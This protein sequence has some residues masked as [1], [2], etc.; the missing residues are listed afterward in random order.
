MHRYWSYIWDLIEGQIHT[1][2]AVAGEI[3]ESERE[4]E[5][6]Q[7]TGFEAWPS[8]PTEPSLWPH[9]GQQCSGEPH[10]PQRFA[11]CFTASPQPILSK[12]KGT[13]SFASAWF[14]IP[15]ASGAS[16]VPFS[17]Q[18]WLAGYI[19][20]KTIDRLFSKP[21]KPSFF[22]AQKTA[23]F[24]SLASQPL[25]TPEATKCRK[26]CCW[27]WRTAWTDWTAGVHWRHG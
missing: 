17:N 16:G 12:L 20:K 5:R 27:S 4:R 9:I 2:G 22:L 1:K 6:E 10:Q 23:L 21:T 19:K 8:R 18:M 26:L 14:L 3:Y 15:S 11:M 7:V 25:S 13:H 24:K